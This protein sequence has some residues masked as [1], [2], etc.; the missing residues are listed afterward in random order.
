MQKMGI[1]GFTIDTNLTY[2]NWGFVKF[3]FE[4]PMV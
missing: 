3:D 4:I 1:R 2:E